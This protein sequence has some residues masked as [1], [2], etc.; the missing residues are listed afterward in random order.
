MHHDTLI[1][2]EKIYCTSTSYS[3]TGLNRWGITVNIKK[4]KLV[5][6]DGESQNNR[7][8]KK[9]FCI[10]FFLRFLSQTIGY[11]LDII[12]SLK[13]IAGAAGAKILK[14]KSPTHGFPMQKQ[15][16]GSVSEAFS[17]AKP[18]KILE[19]FRAFGPNPKKTPPF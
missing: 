9:Y 18:C 8:C 4:Y 3:T 15:C 12:I 1:Q 11:R 14:R 13:T 5:S 6:I 7:V 17:T 16:F 19:K 2:S 10:L